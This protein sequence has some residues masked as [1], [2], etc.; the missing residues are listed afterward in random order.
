MLS[1][2]NICVEN[3]S[4]VERVKFEHMF[5]QISPSSRNAAG[6]QIFSNFRELLFCA[7]F[8]NENI[9]KPTYSQFFGNL[10]NIENEM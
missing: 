1:Q 5:R 2:N 3:D 10:G 8:R 6:E 9:G 7:G 4:D